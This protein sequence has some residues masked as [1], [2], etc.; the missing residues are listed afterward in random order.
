MVASDH[1]LWSN[2][3]FFLHLL[4][5]LTQDRYFN[6]IW[7]RQDDTLEFVWYDLPI[8]PRETPLWIENLGM[9]KDFG[10]IYFTPKK[11]KKRDYCLLR[12][13]FKGI[14]I[15]NRKSNTSLPCY[16]LFYK[17]TKIVRMFW[18]INNLW[19]IVLVNS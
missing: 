12:V 15:L 6:I 16:V 19:F 14:R 4:I 13:V 7:R 10:L 17:I 18:L 9:P 11:M 3:K 2:G 8:K 1:V 5:I